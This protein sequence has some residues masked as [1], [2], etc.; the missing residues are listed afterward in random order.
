MGEHQGF[1]RYTVGQRRGLPGGN[2][3]P[4]YL[5]PIRPARREV[6]VGTTKDLDGRMVILEE[7]NWLAPALEVDSRCEVQVRYRSTA[8]PATVASIGPDR[9]TLVLAPPREP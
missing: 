1:A 6:V 7:I 2:A 3:K 5:V 8:V 9:L 4:L